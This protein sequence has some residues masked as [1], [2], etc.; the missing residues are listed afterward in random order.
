MGNNQLYLLQFGMVLQS[1]T[2]SCDSFLII[3]LPVV[4]KLFGH[5]SA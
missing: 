4:L 5:C 1:E 2:L 3:E